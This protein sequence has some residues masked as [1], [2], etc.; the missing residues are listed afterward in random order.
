MIAD[1]EDKLPPLIDL[2]CGYMD[3]TSKQWI[4]DDQDVEA[5]YGQVNSGSEITI[6][7]EGR[8]HIEQP[9]SEPPSKHSRKYKTPESDN[10]PPTKRADRIDQLTLELHEKHGEAYSMPHL[11]IWAR[12]VLNQQHV[13]VSSFR[14][15]P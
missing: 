1:F 2:E 11:C 8:S 4:E 13:P 12:M 15:V 5:M 14:P 6:W 10:V 9:T 7:S 3:K